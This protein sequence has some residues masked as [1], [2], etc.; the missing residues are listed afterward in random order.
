VFATRFKRPGGQH[1]K[2]ENS[3][4]GYA[5]MGKLAVVAISA[6]LGDRSAQ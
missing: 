1:N 6:A 3:A 5:V 4:K 2:C